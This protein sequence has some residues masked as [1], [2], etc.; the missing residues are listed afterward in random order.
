MAYPRVVGGHPLL[1]DQRGSWRDLAVFG[2]TPLF[3]EPL[4]VNKPNAIDRERLVELIDG[5]LARRWFS[6]GVL[7]REFEEK[8][9]A[10]TGARHCIATCNGTIALQ[11][12]FRALGL[13]G[14]VIVPSFTFVATVQAL[15][16]LGITPVYCDVLPETHNLDPR[17]AERLITPRTS[18]IVGV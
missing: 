1:V 13:S 17:Q 5:M 8:I 3:D 11:I 2:G 9:A 4:H 6:N 12:A 18:A 10:M 7:V 15:R 14:E 16:W